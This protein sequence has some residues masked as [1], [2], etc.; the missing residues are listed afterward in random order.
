M[1]VPI[2]LTYL[3]PAITD[4]KI[5]LRIGNLLHIRHDWALVAGID[6]I[7]GSGGQGVS[8]S[9]LGL[10]ASLNGDDGVGRGCGVGATVA[11]DVVG[12]NVSDGLN[13]C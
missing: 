4:T 10:G 11:D 2:E 8:P 12:R 1:Q 5:G 9:E 6:D 3:E 7:V 13:D